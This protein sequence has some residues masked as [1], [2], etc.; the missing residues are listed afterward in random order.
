VRRYLERRG[1]KLLLGHGAVR[2]EPKRIHLSDGSSIA[3]FTSIWT[4]GVHPPDLVRDLPVTHIKDGR[5]RVDEYLRALDPS[6]SP[7]ED[8]FVMGDCAA[9]T[10]PD[11]TFQPVL[12]QT[13]IAMGGYLGGALVERAEGK[14]ARPFRFHNSGYIISLG[15][16]SSVLELFGMPL[17][18]KLAWLLWAG[19]Y[20]I[21][22]VGFRKQLE[23]GI[24]HLTHLFFEHDFSQILNRRQVLSD[25][26]LNLS[27]GTAGKPESQ[28]PSQ[29]VH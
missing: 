16:H 29:D 10:L 18:G 13:A 24:D 8:V 15:M 22:M 14:P 1:V 19:A 2:V 5:V 23:V 28:V 4:A 3:A 21:K 9:A 20:L 11:G 25:S 6:G 27:L 17:S 26:E 7:L 12:A